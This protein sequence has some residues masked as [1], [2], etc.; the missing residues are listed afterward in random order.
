MP[1]DVI[2]A[3]QAVAPDYV[4]S[5][6]VLQRLNRLGYD[7]LTENERALLGRFPEDGKTICQAAK[8][9]AMQDARWSEFEALVGAADA[10]PFGILTA[11]QR[12]DVTAIARRAREKGSGVLSLEEVRMLIRAGADDYLKRESGR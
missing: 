7:A 2:T 10:T 11:A 12:E 3:A 9:S 1:N 4:E 8:A 6:R 5:R